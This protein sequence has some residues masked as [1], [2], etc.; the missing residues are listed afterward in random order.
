MRNVSRVAQN[1]PVIPGRGQLQGMA[2]WAQALY[3]GPGEWPGDCQVAADAFGGKFQGREEVFV[4]RFQGVAGGGRGDIDGG[5]D[6][7]GAV[8]DGDRD[9]SQS[10]L[11]FLVDDRPA[12]FPYPPQFFPECAPGRDGVGGQAREVQGREVGIQLCR[13][14]SGEQYPAH[15]GRVGGEPG[16]EVDPD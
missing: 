8:A 11:E 12:L 15:R 2:G 5:D 1:W 16:A 13:G 9:R 7:P 6:C 4:D 10:L 3:A 14:E